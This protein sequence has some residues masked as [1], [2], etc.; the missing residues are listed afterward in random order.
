MHHRANLLPV[1]RVVVARVIVL[2]LVRSVLRHSDIPL[3]YAH[4]NKMRKGI[5]L[6]IAF[7]Y[8]LFI[9]AGCAVRDDVYSYDSSYDLLDAN[10]IELPPLKPVSSQKIEEVARWARRLQV[11]TYDGEE[12]PTAWSMINIAC[13]YRALALEWALAYGDRKGFDA[14]P[15]LR[16]DEITENNIRDLILEPSYESASINLTGPLATLQTLVLPDGTR[17]SGE[18]FKNAWPYHHGVVVNVDGEL[19]VIDLSIQDRPVTINE[20]IHSFVDPSVACFLM[21][22]NEFDELWSYW[23]AIYNAMKPGNRP[24]RLCGFTITPMFTFSSDQKPLV[25][26]LRGAPSILKEQF[27]GFK[28]LIY[29]EYS[30]IIDDE[31]VPEITSRYDSQPESVLCEWMELDCK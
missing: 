10:G 3:I 26:V 16:E 19:K 21:K 25:D 31:I 24:E 20:W 9:F 15:V 12:R 30:L 4:K 18:P 1:L 17:I 27:D 29:R 11:V 23:N 13:Q 7:L 2:V 8:L 14:P 22:D 6:S 28:Q 5:S